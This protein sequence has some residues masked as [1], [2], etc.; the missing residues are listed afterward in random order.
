M[1]CLMAPASELGSNPTTMCDLHIVFDT[2]LPQ[3]PS[4]VLLSIIIFGAIV[5]RI[6]TRS[7]WKWIN[8]MLYI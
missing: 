6:P 3:R 5:W 7:Q 1:I 2:S 4:L 8:V